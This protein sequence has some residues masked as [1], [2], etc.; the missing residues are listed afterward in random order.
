MLALQKLLDS[1]TPEQRQALEDKRAARLAARQHP[2]NMLI[3]LGR[4]T[5]GDFRPTVTV[6]APDQPLA[7]KR[8]PNS[9]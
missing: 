7:K 1:M 3:N 2:L 4:Q 9:D 6:P 8:K 5:N